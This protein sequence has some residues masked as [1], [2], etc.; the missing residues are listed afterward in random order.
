MRI[1]CMELWAL[2]WRGLSH[3]GWISGI[4]GM[5]TTAE[6]LLQLRESLWQWEKWAQV[7]SFRP[8]AVCWDHSQL[9]QPEDWV[10]TCHNGKLERSR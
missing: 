6:M 3:L 5:V 4:A 9:C 2:H 8:K 7:W 10:L 1:C